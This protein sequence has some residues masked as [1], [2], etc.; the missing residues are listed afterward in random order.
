[1]RSAVLKMLFLACF[2]HG[3]VAAGSDINT[4]VFCV[5]HEFH[6]DQ[7]VI[8]NVFFLNGRSSLYE[9]INENIER[10]NDTNVFP[11]LLY[12]FSFPDFY[13]CSDLSGLQFSSNISRFTS[14]CETEIWRGETLFSP[15]ITWIPKSLS[16]DSC[17]WG[18]GMVKRLPH[19]HT[20]DFISP[21]REFEWGSNAKSASNIETD[22]RLL[23][24]P[25][26]TKI[27]ETFSHLPSMRF[28]H[29]DWQILFYY[30]EQSRRISYHVKFILPKQDVPRIEIE[31]LMQLVRK[32]I[33]AAPSNASKESK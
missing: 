33:E 1:M 8:S 31:P 28:T 29:G 25:K 30:L 3:F 27:I 26:G 10:V 15:Y 13:K 9:I 6:P 16:V 12:S 4:K 19:L 5:V 11:S 7:I 2:F 20:R 14:A 21:G 18:Q 22:C 24:F 32:K 23:A 17:Y